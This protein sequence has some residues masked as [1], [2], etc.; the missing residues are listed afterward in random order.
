[1]RSASRKAVQQAPRTEGRIRTTV[2]LRADLR[3]WLTM[4]AKRERKTAAAVLE[5]I[6]A[7]AR[8]EWN[9]TV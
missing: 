7:A 3:E 8:E 5:E 1:M 9:L 2:R 4:R 6:L